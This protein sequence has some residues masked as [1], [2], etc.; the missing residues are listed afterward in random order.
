M[1]KIPAQRRPHYP[2][3]ERLAILEFRHGPHRDFSLTSFLVIIA[4]IAI[5]SGR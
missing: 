5:G 4:R 2:P 1:L 3:T